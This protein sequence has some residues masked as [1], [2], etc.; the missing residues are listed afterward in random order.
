MSLQRGVPLAGGLE[1]QPLLL[2]DLVF[3]ALCGDLVRGVVFFDE[4]VYDGVRLPA[5]YEIRKL[6]F[7]CVGPDAPHHKTVVEVV[8]QR[9]D[10]AVGVVLGKRGIF[11]LCLLRVEEDRLEGQAE[12]TQDHLHFPT[13]PM[14]IALST[15]G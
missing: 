6:R 9:G 3:E 2:D 12:F 10:A 14:N 15:R 8:D 7:I 1:V 5:I 4:V 11:V 13:G